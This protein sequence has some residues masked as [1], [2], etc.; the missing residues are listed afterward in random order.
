M[1][2]VHV[3][4]S[5]DQLKQALRQLP[6]Q[7]KIAVWRMLDGDLDRD[8]IA[9]RF[10]SA[11]NA[12]RKTYASRLRGP[13]AMRK[14]VLDTN[15]LI[16]GVIASGFSASILNAFRREEIHLVTSPHLLAEFSE[17][18]SRRHIARKYPQAAENAEAL[19]DYLRAFAT[20]APGIPEPGI[21]SADR[22]DDFVLAC[23]LDGKVD[24]IVSG[25]PHLLDLKSFEDI[26]I[27]TPREF[28]ERI[29]KS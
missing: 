24:F 23:A 5:L 22:D 18:V 21:I 12:V 3:D 7:E 19:L 25:D 8:A 14:V 27:L 2:T 15:V 20:L 11:L 28:V 10:T 16:S 17:V 26:P 9:R 1:N 29:L 4:L 6:A 13:C